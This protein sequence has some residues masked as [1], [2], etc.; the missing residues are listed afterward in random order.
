MAKES[1]MRIMES[2]K[3]FRPLSTLS[4]IL[5]LKQELLKKMMN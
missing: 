3:N 4:G 1:I 2:L 5:L